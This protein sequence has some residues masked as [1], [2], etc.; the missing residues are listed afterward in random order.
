MFLSII[1]PIYND[2]K[3]LRECLDSCLNQDVSPDEYE[4]ICVDDGSTDNT[5]EIMR[6]YERF[7]SNI[8]LVFQEHGAAS[9]RDVGLELARGDYVWFVDHDDLI[10]ESCLGTLKE[11]TQQTKC[12]RLVF[13]YY[14]FNINLSEKEIENKMAGKLDIKKMGDFPPE[15]SI[16]ASIYSRHFLL[17]NNIWPRS[18]QISRLGPVYGGDEFFAHECNDVIRNQQKWMERPLYFHRVFWGSE[19]HRAGKRNLEKK[20]E[21]LFNRSMA[22]MEKACQWQELYKKERTECGQASEETTVKLITW[23]RE[24]RVVLSTLGITYWHR[25]NA[26]LKERGLDNFKKPEEYSYHCLDHV[27]NRGSAGGS[28]LKRIAYYYSYTKL[29]SILYRVLDY[30][31]HF[32]RFIQK[33]ELLTQIKRNILKQSSKTE[34]G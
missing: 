29:G 32:S 26:C 18:R 6:E 31:T 4:I 20:Q 24:S 33:S 14:P 17:D 30:K 13:P 27:K 11:I 22:C 12:E 25:G 16:W 5:P 2:E 15:I 34:K 23:L 1:I 7:Y 19:S 10:D 8:R 21:L 9:G 28:I 3:Y